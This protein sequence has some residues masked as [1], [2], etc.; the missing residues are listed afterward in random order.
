MN[1]LTVTVAGL[2]AEF[3]EFEAGRS[4]LIASLWALDEVL[5]G[6]I[7]RGLLGSKFTVT[8]TVVTAAPVGPTTVGL[9]AAGRSGR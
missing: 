1:G 8:D 7:T 5:V 9:L 2:V 6:T 3:T 4:R